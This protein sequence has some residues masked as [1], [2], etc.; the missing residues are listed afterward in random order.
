MG[1]IWFHFP[2]IPHSG[3][4]PHFTCFFWLQPPILWNNISLKPWC[5]TLA[6]SKLPK[7]C[8]TP[9]QITVV[10][11]PIFWILVKFVADFYITIDFYITLWPECH[12]NDCGELFYEV[13]TLFLFSCVLRIYFCYFPPILLVWHYQLLIQLHLQNFKNFK[14]DFINCCSNWNLQ[15]T[16]WMSITANSMMDH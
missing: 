16:D 11:R 5:C 15:T 8:N 1:L 3:Q 2:N 12:K 7:F 6:A 9:P 10:R 13:V 14:R 4:S